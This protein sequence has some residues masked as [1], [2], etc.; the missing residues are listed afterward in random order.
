MSFP[1]PVSRRILSSVT[2]AAGK[3]ALI[4]AGVLLALA[5]IGVFAGF[6]TC[7]PQPALTVAK[8]DETVLASDAAVP[9]GFQDEGEGEDGVK[10]ATEA[11]RAPALAVY[12]S[13]AV[14]SPGVYELAEGARVCD[15]V[16]AAGG[17]RDDAAAGAVNLAR[18]VADGEQ[19]AVPTNEEAAAGSVSAVDVEAPAAATA[20]LVNINTA[21]VDELDAL[22]GVGPATAQAIVDEREANGPFSSV[23][24]IMRVSGIGEKKFA[25]LRESTCV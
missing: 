14:A 13:G 15:A 11:D 10:P 6:S 17:L 18:K 24:D 19:V 7:S 5:L 23:E 2:I 16:A 3:P 1:E 8:S 22:A 20:A 25:K 12:V 21:G 4:G 9:E